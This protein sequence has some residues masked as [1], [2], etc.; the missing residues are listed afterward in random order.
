MSNEWH[1]A[2][3]GLSL[4]PVPEEKLRE[5]I[6]SGGLKPTDQV[7]KIG[8]SYW[9]AIQSVSEL[10]ASTHQ[11]IQPQPTSP[12][13]NTSIVPAASPNQLWN[14]LQSGVTLGPVPEE[15]LRELLASGVLRGSDLVW[16]EGMDA[17]ANIITIPGLIPLQPTHQQIQPPPTFPPL[18]T[19]TRKDPSTN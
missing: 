2:Q 7:W 12:I 14:Y 6:A 16:H 13:L 18:G 11:Q 15:K 17:W 3:N 4:G 19:S 5:L 1:Y 8:M 10:M 9:T